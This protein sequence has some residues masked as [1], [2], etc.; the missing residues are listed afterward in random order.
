MVMRIVAPLTYG[1][2]VNPKTHFS[3]IHDIIII[4][5][6]IIIFLC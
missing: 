1:D 2:F 6:I 4:I 3:I 5:I